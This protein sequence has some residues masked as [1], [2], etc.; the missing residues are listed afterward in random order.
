MAKTAKKAKAR[1]PKAKKTKRSARKATISLR[2]PH[3]WPLPKV[4][5]LLLPQFGSSTGF[6]L[7]E[8]L[9]SGELR[10][11]RRPVTNPGQCEEVPPSFWQSL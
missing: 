3:W 7:S 11:V 5:K 6:E 4:Y 8:A 10:C 1:K 2:D 9:K